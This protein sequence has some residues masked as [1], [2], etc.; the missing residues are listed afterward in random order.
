MT[1]APFDPNS[2]GYANFIKMV[3]KAGCKESLEEVD[4]C[5]QR[6]NGNWAVCQKQ[7][8]AFNKCMRTKK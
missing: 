5:K 6:E 1:R 4:L 7:L 3:E 8:E 2:D